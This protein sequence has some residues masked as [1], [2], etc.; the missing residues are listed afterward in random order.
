M[1]RRSVFLAIA[2]LALAVPHALG[3]INPFTTDNGFE[4]VNS[5]GAYTSSFNGGFPTQGAAAGSGLCIGLGGLANNP[6]GYMLWTI[7][8][9]ELMASGNGSVPP[10]M[11]LTGDTFALFSSQWGEDK[12]WN[13]VPIHTLT[14]PA[15]WTAPVFYDVSITSVVYANPITN[16]VDG[17]RYPN[18]AVAPQAIILGGASGLPAP[19]PS[20]GCPAPGQ[21]GYFVERTWANNTPLSGVMVTADG[22]TDTALVHWQPSGMTQTNPADP[23]GCEIGGNWSNEYA[24]SISEHMPVNFPS[25]T[26]HRNVYHGYRSSATNYSNM[27]VV[28]GGVQNIAWFLEPTFRDP[29]LQFN[30]NNTDGAAL[31]AFLGAERG[32]AQLHMDATAATA[33]IFPGMRITATG[34]LGQYVITV[35][36]TGAFPGVGLFAQPGYQV[37]PPSAGYLLL[38]FTDPNFFILDQNGFSGFM[39]TNVTDY[40]YDRDV[41]DTPTAFGPFV[42]PV[43]APGIS[44]SIQSF[45]VTSFSPV[46]VISTNVAQ[47]NLF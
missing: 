7:L 17:R 14:P 27:A 12:D 34:H 47:G 29:I 32:S 31:P 10:K 1:S 16:I 45:I 25:A 30:Y 19:D 36:S 40:A 21:D 37:T 15:P 35:L 3:Q 39:G 5:V 8:P 6:N 41:Y 33:A 9:R 13:G 20:F 18:L 2:V 28:A 4:L 22:L 26:V 42:G 46:T 11:E 38:D 44:Y 43:A 24:L 23:S